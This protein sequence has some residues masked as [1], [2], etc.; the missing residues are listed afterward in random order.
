MGYWQLTYWDRTE[1]KRD[2]PALQ[3]RI[4]ELLT[5]STCEKFTVEYIKDKK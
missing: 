5:Q 4:T 1:I 3:E 2:V